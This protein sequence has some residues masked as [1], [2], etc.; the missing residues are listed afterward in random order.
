MIPF[1]VLRERL[2]L[3]GGI[4]SKGRTVRYTDLIEAT[5]RVLEALP[6][7]GPV[8]IQ[9]KADAN[10]QFKYLEM[11]PR[12]SGAVMITAAASADPMACLVKE[13]RHEAVP[14]IEWKE[15]TVIRYFDEKIP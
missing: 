14:L 3:S 15:V 2:Q 7:R 4:C 5:Q 12:L 9:W 13:L 1:I 8:C 6:C 10:G 11:N